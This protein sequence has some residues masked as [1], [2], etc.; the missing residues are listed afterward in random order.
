MST[1]VVIPISRLLLLLY[2]HENKIRIGKIKARFL[3][4]VEKLKLCLSGL[5]QASFE[6]AIADSANCATFIE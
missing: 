5:N 2:I 6:N 4:S 1:Y 3:Y